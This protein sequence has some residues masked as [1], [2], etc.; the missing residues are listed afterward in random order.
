MSV[1]D[2]SHPISNYSD[3]RQTFLQLRRY[4]RFNV[5]LLLED[6]AGKKRNHFLWFIICERVLKDE[7]SKD[8]FID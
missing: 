8:K 5:C 4:N 1:L 6:K 2:A 7:F 3:R